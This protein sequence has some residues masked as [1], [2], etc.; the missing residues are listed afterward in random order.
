MLASGDDRREELAL[1]ARGGIHNLQGEAESLEVAVVERV[2]SGDVVVLSRVRQEKVVHLRAA[3][4]AKPCQRSQHPRERSVLGR[5][6]RKYREVFPNLCENLSMGNGESRQNGEELPH[7]L[8]GDA[9]P[10][11]SRSGPGPEC[12]TQVGM[13]QGRRRGPEED[14]RVEENDPVHG[15]FLS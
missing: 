2:E 14:P 5:D 8:L 4:P 10:K 3:E 13:V 15:R 11:P 12:K 7:A 9:R 6:D 1:R